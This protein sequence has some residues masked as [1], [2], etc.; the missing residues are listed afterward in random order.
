MSYSVYADAASTFT[1]LGVVKSV[2]VGCYMCNNNEITI[3][4]GQ[5]RNHEMETYI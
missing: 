4:S 3:N 5:L 2:G 1:L